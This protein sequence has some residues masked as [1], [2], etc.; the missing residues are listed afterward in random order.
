MLDPTLIDKQA[1]VPLGE[2]KDVLANPV[3]T[4]EKAENLPWY[5]RDVPGT[6]ECLQ[7]LSV[8][9]IYVPE[10]RGKNDTHVHSSKQVSLNSLGALA[11]QSFSFYWERQR[12]AVVKLA[13]LTVASAGA[14][15]GL[16]YLNANLSAAVSKSLDPS[17]NGSL[18]LALGAFGVIVMT[19]MA[20]KAF[21]LVKQ[22]LMLRTNHRTQR[23]IRN[24]LTQHSEL[25]SID[26]ASGQ[27]NADTSQ[28]I[29]QN[30]WEKNKIPE[31]ASNVLYSAVQVGISAAFISTQFP[32]IASALVVSA[33]PTFTSS[34]TR[35]LERCCKDLDFIMATRLGW[36]RD[37]IL[38]NPKDLMPFRR[39]AEVKGVKDLRNAVVDT[40]NLAEKRLD[41]RDITS[42]AIASFIQYSTIGISGYCVLSADLANGAAL[43][44]TLGHLGLITGAAVGLS[45]LMRGASDLAK[46]LLV[47]K[48]FYDFANENITLRE[49]NS[50]KNVC[51]EMK[52]APRINLKGVSYEVDG[53]VIL[54]NIS[55][56]IA[57]GEILG[58]CGP[59][60]QG[61]ST[62]VKVIQGMIAPTTG[63]IHVTFDEVT[64]DMRKTKIDSWNQQVASLAQGDRIMD[65]F[66]IRDNLKFGNRNAE[67]TAESFCDLL[68]IKEMLTEMKA[69]PDSMVG[70][71]WYGGI[72][73]SGGENQKLL[74]E[75]VFANNKKVIIID[76]PLSGIDVKQ[77]KVIQEAIIKE[78]RERHVTI[79]FVT[80]GLADLR[81]ADRILVIDK[82]KIANQGTPQELSVLS[83]FYRDGSMDVL[84]ANLEIFDE[85][86][87]ISHTESET[88]IRLKK[89]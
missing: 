7:L 1:P 8:P 44:T 76:E 63:D 55:L 13:S 54:N 60:G 3:P 18:A 87:E 42:S 67:S 10:Q 17:Q 48:P 86:P 57:R 64:Y 19:Q 12:D 66:T 24:E 72:T 62:L 78:A 22:G 68:K 52:T 49:E 77:A 69:T 88:I 53:K 15:I 74:L 41:N 56:D 33:I 31:S 27:Q 34:L 75:R 11:C 51:E 70:A 73:P 71:G 40:T 65:G 82:G 58:I 84:I 30:I 50:K 85:N 61:K 26:Q 21:A 47:M 35:A 83:G 79:I 29:I 25:L 39:L 9:K 81:H 2:T 16:V 46:S 23:L 37:W 20:D 89:I 4:S 32:L 14:A 6:P 5:R 59:S 28:L 38:A 45:G 43:A 80:H 36:G